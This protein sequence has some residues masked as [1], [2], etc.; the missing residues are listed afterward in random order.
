MGTTVATDHHPLHSARLNRF[1]SKVKVVGAASGVG[2][3]SDK[4]CEI[5]EAPV[6]FKF[7]KEKNNVQPLPD[8][9]TPVAFF[10]YIV[11]FNHCLINNWQQSC[12]LETGIHI[13]NASS[14]N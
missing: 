4:I 11:M 8:F 14:V 5:V 13:L 10:P 3:P 6:S 2:E 9:N 1:S 7:F 12:C